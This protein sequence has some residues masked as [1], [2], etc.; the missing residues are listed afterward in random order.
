MVTTTKIEARAHSILPRGE[1]RACCSLAAGPRLIP[2]LVMAAKAA[3][4][5]S[6][7]VSDHQRGPQIVT[8]A[9]MDGMIE[10]QPV[11]G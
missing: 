1:I 6:R 9:R 3:N 10:M 2:S 8:A 7:G 11:D 5:P 4:V